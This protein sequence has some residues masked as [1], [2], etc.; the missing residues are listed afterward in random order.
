[1]AYRTCILVDDMMSDT[2]AT[3]AKAAEALFA[4][5]G[6]PG[7]RHRHT[8]GVLSGTA[9]D[10]LKNSQISEIIITEHAAGAGGAS[11]P[12][13]LTVLSIARRQRGPGRSTEVFSTTAPRHRAR[14]ISARAE[15]LR[16]G[17]Q[18]QV[19][20]KT[21]V[22]APPEA[23]GRRPCRRL[24]GGPGR[25]AGPL[26]PSPA[27][28][29][30]RFSAAPTPPGETAVRALRPDDAPLASGTHRRPQAR[31]ADATPWWVAGGPRTD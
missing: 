7:H 24:P 8:T 31:G 30:D 9:V 23:R 28:D 26:P 14:P 3:I 11:C 20:G 16:P 29:Q 27:G 5:A 1:M 17:S 4:E 22:P 15:P 6:R 18:G 25:R 10:M 12:T 21:V 2:G 13:S 19:P